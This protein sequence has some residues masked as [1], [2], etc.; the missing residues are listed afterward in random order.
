MVTDEKLQKTIAMRSGKLVLNRECQCWTDDERKKLKK[1]FADGE[2][3]T[4]IAIMLERSETA[5]LQQVEHMKLRE[6]NIATSRRPSRVKL[7]SHCLC[8]SC[9]CDPALCPRCKDDK[10]EK[11]NAKC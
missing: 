9:M 3:I 6:R 8:E 1:Y 2:G 5:I 7:P 11:E 10:N 4:D